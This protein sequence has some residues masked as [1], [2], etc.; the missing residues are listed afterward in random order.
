[1]AN[2]KKRATW[3]VGLA[4]VSSMTGAVFALPVTAA[5]SADDKTSFAM[6]II[7]D[8]H[9]FDPGIISWEAYQDSIGIFEGL[10]KPGPKGP[11]PGIAVSWTHSKDYKTWTFHLRKNAKFSNGDPVTAQCFVYSW[12]RAYSPSTAVRDGGSSALTNEVPVVNGAAIRAGEKLPQSLGVKALDDYTFQVKLERPDPNLIRDLTLPTEIWS[13]PLDPKVHMFKNDWMQADKI[14][15]DGPYM[16]KSYTPKTQAVLVPNPYYYGKVNLKQIVFLYSAS[17]NALLAYK[18][19]QLDAALLQSTDIPAVKA[20]PSLS[21]DLHFFPTSVQYTLQ[22]APS[23]NTTLQNPLVRKALMMAI[24]RKTIAEKVLQGAAVPA[25]EYFCPT[26]LDPWITQGAVPYDPAQAR[27]LLAQAGFPNGKGFPTLVIRVPQVGQ[28]DVVAQAVQQMWENNLHINVKYDGEEAGQFYSTIG[29]QLPAN[30]V[31]VVQ[32]SGNFKYPQ[33]LL[34]Q[35]LDQYLGTQYHSLYWGYLPPD[36]YQQVHQLDTNQSLDP[37][38][39]AKKEAALYKKYLP[40]N[41]LDWINTGVKAYQTN[42]DN[43]MKEFYLKHEQNVFEFPI[44]TPL[45]PVLIRSD[46]KGYTP[47]DFLLTVPPIWLNDITRQ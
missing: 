1:M 39:R 22:I 4:A 5:A 18:S 25:Y 44:Y 46:V 9:G 12:Q 3:A 27:K 17:Q 41:V 29:Q 33:L 13:A 32:S 37:T 16:L 2:R 23:Q 40:K 28:P 10:V 35:S 7:D 36:V 26:W 38:V 24:D 11:R 31:G 45:E 19:G 30:E 15:S 20:D 43:L 42:D 6:Y 14:V 8:G 47:N 21:K 34:P